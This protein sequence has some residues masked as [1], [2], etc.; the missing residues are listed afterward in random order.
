[1]AFLA[2]TGF[3]PDPTSAGLGGMVDSSPR[4]N[5]DGTPRDVVFETPRELTEE[6][7][8]AMGLNNNSNFLPDGTPLTEEQKEYFEGVEAIFCKARN[9]RYEE[10]EAQLLNGFSA[11]TTDRHGNTLLMIASQNGLKRVAKL[12]L[13]HGANMN[14]ANHRG[15]TALHYCFQ[16]GYDA[17]GEYLISK[18]ADPSI[19]NSNGLKCREGLGGKA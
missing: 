12:V 18:G 2:D 10:V 5:S 13:R 9:N 19:C 16:Y 7:L 6:E 15:H 11:N 4:T 17:L 14:D 1:M 3:V 8:I